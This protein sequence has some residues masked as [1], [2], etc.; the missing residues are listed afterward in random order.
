MQ[1]LHEDMLW[2]DE[3]NL[4]ILNS[5]KKDGTPFTQKKSKIKQAKMNLIEWQAEELNRKSIVVRAEYFEKIGLDWGN[6]DEV[7]IIKRISDLR[8]KISH[9]T[10]NE[11]L[12]RGFLPKA[13]KVLLHVPLRCHQRAQEL[14]P[15]Y[16]GLKNV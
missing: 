3:R 11:C 7:S 12:D 15:S 14:F 13:R 2:A 16:F 10:V 8:N 6:S 4:K 9:E 1:D 5:A